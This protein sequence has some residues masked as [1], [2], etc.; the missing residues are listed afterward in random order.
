VID[1]HVPTGLPDGEA[2]MRILQHIADAKKVF[3]EG[4]FGD[5]GRVCYRP[6]ANAPHDVGHLPV[7]LS[8]RA[9]RIELVA[10]T[11]HDRYQWEIT[12]IRFF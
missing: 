12:L 1:L 4:R 5:V 2:A 3:N 8:E 11:V 6:P 10:P 7:H 9:I